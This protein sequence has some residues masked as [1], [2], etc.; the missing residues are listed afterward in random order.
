MSAYVINYKC[1]IIFILL[2]VRVVQHSFK[3][4]RNC[5]KKNKKYAKCIVAVYRMSNNN[6]NKKNFKS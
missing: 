4:T 1:I 3:S 2:N 6:N 5:T